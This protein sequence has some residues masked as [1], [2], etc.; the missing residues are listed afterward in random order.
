MILELLSFRVRP[1]GQGALER[2][3]IALR[4]LL[5]NNPHCLS[6]LLQRCLE[7]PARYM[8]R[9]EWDSVA[10][11]MESFRGSPDYREFLRVFEPHVEGDAEMVHFENA[12]P[13]G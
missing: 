8:A 10:G 5:M 7:E 3:W 4:R 13:R 6:V 9:I 2:D 11:H 1:G 12:G